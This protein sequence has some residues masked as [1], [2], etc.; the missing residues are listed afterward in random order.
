MNFFPRFNH[1]RNNVHVVNWTILSLV[2]QIEYTETNL[3]RVG[4]EWE[5]VELSRYRIILEMK[6]FQVVQKN[7][8]VLGIAA[9]RPVF[10][11]KLVKICLFYGLDLTLSAVFLFSEAKT[12][13]EYTSNIYITTALLVISSY[14]SIWI[15]KLGKFF[16][17]ID[18]VEKLS[19]KSETNKYNFIEL[20]LYK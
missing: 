13:L 19:G 2:I 17:L 5:N 6:Y 16:N 3:V 11:I 7:L 9:N 14:F 18:D 15:L 4:T 12:F 20:V 1:Y 8:T 10:N